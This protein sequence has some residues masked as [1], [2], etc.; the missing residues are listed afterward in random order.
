[1]TGRAVVEGYRILRREHERQRRWEEDA[2]EADRAA[3]RMRYRFATIF[4]GAL[5]S[6]GC[7]A[8]AEPRIPAADA[9]AGPTD[10]RCLATTDSI[11]LVAPESGCVAATVR[12]SGRMS[13]RAQGTPVLVVGRDDRL[14]WIRM[15][16]ACEGAGSDALIWSSNAP[17]RCDVGE[18]VY[19][20]WSALECRPGTE[21]HAVDQRSVQVPG[22]I[23]SEHRIAG[24]DVA[25]EW[26]V[27]SE[28]LRT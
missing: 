9:G 18:S 11:V 12:A 23:V 4:L 7:C 21:I 1:M 10:P 19:A 6:T 20:A 24:E 27:C 28:P 16:L 5:V 26:L 2:P 22:R 8:S 15:R 25:V 17:S 13:T 3:S 14:V